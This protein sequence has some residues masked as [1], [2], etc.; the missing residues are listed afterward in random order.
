MVTLVRPFNRKEIASGCPEA[1]TSIA[2]I[3][4][5]ANNKNMEADR[6]LNYERIMVGVII[7]FLL[8]GESA[9]KIGRVEFQ[10]D[11]ARDSKKLERQ[12]FLDRVLLKQIPEPESPLSLLQLQDLIRLSLR[13]CIWVELISNHKSVHFGYDL[14]VYF[15]G[16]RLSRQLKTALLEI[17]MQVEELRTLP[18][19]HRS[20]R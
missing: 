7:C 5:Q 20:S 6:F 12:H 17:G 4:R 16:G 11:F 2:D 14:Y 10:K 18:S 19:G 13:T 9:V 15:A 3:G 8:G 1:F